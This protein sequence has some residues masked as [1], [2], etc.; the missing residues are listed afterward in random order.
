[1]ALANTWFGARWERK[2]D[3]FSLRGS[4][5]VKLVPDGSGVIRSEVFPGL[6]LSSSDMI[7]GDLA[8]VLAVLQNGLASPEHADLVQKLGQK[9]GRE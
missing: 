2:L 8:A 3:W 1:M 4:E 9:G 6:W 7:R 5:F